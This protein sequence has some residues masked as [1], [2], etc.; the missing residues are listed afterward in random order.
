MNFISWS[1]G[2]LH[3]TYS[4]HLP[5]IFEAVGAATEGEDVQM[6]VDIAVG[7]GGGIS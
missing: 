4:C 7:G 5:L 3:I 6:W 2:I 1:Q